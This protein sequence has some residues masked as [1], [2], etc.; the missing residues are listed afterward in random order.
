MSF[1]KTVRL[2]CSYTLSLETG[3]EIETK[4]VK[5]NFFFFMHITL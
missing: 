2:L 1:S 3:A 5:K 4:Q